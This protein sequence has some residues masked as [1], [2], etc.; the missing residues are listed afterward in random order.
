MCRSSV[1]VTRLQTVST[2]TRSSTQDHPGCGPK[3]HFAL[4]EWSGVP[5][6]P[7]AAGP[8]VGVWPERPPVRSKGEGETVREACLGL[9]EAA[10]RRLGGLDTRGE[11]RHSTSRGETGVGVRGVGVRS[12]VDARCGDTD[13]TCRAGAA[14]AG[15][16]VISCWAERLAHLRK[17]S[18]EKG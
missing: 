6:T 8:P 7:L 5:H 9:G 15:R 18:A 12:L 14:G 10:H 1:T 13:A 4:L 11:R 3:A 16:S 17:A 2:R